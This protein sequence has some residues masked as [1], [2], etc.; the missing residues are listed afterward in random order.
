VCLLL[1][2]FWV[3]GGRGNG[4]IGQSVSLALAFGASRRHR[5]TYVL[6]KSVRVGADLDRTAIVA[7]VAAME[8]A[9]HVECLWQRPAGPHGTLKRLIIH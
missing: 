8:E 6:L 2:K 9:R 1:P 5:P 4:D 7:T 3:K